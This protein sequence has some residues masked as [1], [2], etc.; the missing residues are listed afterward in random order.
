[1][2]GAILV[3]NHE[4]SPEAIAAVQVWTRQVIDL[5]IS[6]GGTYYLP[7]AAYA[8]REQAGAAYA[9]LPEFVAAKDHWDP[10][11]VFMNWF[12]HHYG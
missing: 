6:M 10:N 9:R 1:M 8:T 7:Y 12:F 5:A 11:H 2:F 3:V 4:T